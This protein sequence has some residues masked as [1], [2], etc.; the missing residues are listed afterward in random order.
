[1]PHTHQC[2]RCGTTWECDDANYQDECPYP[3][4]I[5]CTKCWSQQ[6]PEDP[7]VRKQGNK[8]VRK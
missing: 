3:T 8:D 4:E 5:L 7:E 6:T 1:M 2:P